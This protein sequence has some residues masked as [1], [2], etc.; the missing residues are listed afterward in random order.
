MDGKMYRGLT[1]KS[2][3]NKVLIMVLIGRIREHYEAAILPYQYGFRANKWTT[4]GALV[5]RQM[6]EKTP[7]EI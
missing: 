7:D 2:T 6:I 1:I 5:S 3:M 4:D